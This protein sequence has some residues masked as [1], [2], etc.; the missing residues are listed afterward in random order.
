MKSGLELSKLQK[1]L[2]ITAISPSALRGQGN[3]GIVN[4][5]REYCSKID[6]GKMASIESKDRFELELN[7]LT[8][9]ICRKAGVE[10][11]AGRKAINLFLRE[12]L[13]N[14]YFNLRFSFGKMEGYMEIP[15]DSITSKA[16]KKEKGGEDLPRWKGLVGLTREDS[17]EFQDFADR[18]AKGCGMA[19]VHLDIELWVRGRGG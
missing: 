9:G 8:N 6:I 5:A 10:W 13:Y 7:R 16:L 17:E 4:S 11:G 2:A 12:I 3:G 18:L 1:K 19:R 14:H 15:L